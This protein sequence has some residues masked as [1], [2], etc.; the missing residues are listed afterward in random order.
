MEKLEIY[1][2]GFTELSNEDCQ[3]ID[4]GSELSQAVFFSLGMV[5]RCFYELSEGAHRGSQVGGGIFF[6]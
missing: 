5:C 2:N 6:K 4:G 3:N 1:Q